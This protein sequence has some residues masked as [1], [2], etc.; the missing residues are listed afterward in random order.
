MIDQH[1][2]DDKWFPTFEL[3]LVIR[4]FKGNDTGKRKNFITN[5]PARLEDFFLKNSVKPQK[6]RPTRATTDVEA[7]KILSGDQELQNMYKK[8]ENQI[9]E[10]NEQSEASK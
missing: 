1:V 6:K 3:D 4:D 10:L 9:K 7:S 8:R 2:P 5:D